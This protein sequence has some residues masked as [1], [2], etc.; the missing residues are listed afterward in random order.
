MATK[1]QSEQLAWQKQVIREEYIQQ[2]IQQKKDE[3]PKRL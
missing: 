3:K 2:D 1:E